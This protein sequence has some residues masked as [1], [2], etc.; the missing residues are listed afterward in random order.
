MPF[1]NPADKAAWRRARRASGAEARDQL[2]LKKKKKRLGIPANV[3][4]AGAAAYHAR[5]IRICRGCGKPFTS[6]QPRFYCSVNCKPAS[7]A[8]DKT[9]AWCDNAYTTTN[10]QSKTCSNTCRD[11]LRFH[12][13]AER[14]KKPEYKQKK[15]KA[16]RKQRKHQRAAVN[17]IKALGLSP[18]KLPLRKPNVQRRK[19]IKHQN[20]K[21]SLD[22]RMRFKAN[23]EIAKKI[24]LV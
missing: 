4:L 18:D 19:E 1:K 17:A 23:L 6:K 12:S 2:K 5:K 16:T 8:Y 7:P 10:P 20:P 9:C 21:V 24:G 14:N 22:A 13:R 11:G 15:N 3:S